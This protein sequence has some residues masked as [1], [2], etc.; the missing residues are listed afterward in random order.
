MLHPNP[1]KRKEKRG[2]PFLEGQLK[3]YLSQTILF[4]DLPPAELKKLQS[5]S[6]WI[7]AEAGDIIVRHARHH[8]N[9]YLVCSGE[10]WGFENSQLILKARSGG[11]FGAR[12]LL[13]THGGRSD[14]IC[15]ERG[16]LL[17]LDKNLFFEIL[18]TDPR[19]L[20]R[21]VTSSVWQQTSL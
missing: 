21:I 13:S 1:K 8:A 12:A 6:R 11:Y 16:G 20:L 2:L 18:K 4:A 5:R 3:T 9:F 10:F 19:Y 7:E 17:V 14:L 15:A